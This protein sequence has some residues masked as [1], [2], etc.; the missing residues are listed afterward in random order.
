MNNTFENGLCIIIPA[1]Y[2]ASEYR[3]AMKLSDFVKKQ[4]NLY[5]EVKS[6]DFVTTDDE[7]KK[8][9]FIGLYYY[10]KKMIPKDKLSLP[11][12][13]YYVSANESTAYAYADSIEGYEG[14]YSYVA[15][16]IAQ[17]KLF[18][19]LIYIGTYDGTVQPEKTEKN[20]YRL[21][22]SN[23]LGWC[24]KLPLYYNSRRVRMLAELYNSYSPDVIGLQECWDAPTRDGNCSIVD[25]LAVCGYTEVPVKVKNLRNTNFTPLF[26]KNGKFDLLDYGYMLYDGELNDV[27]SKSVTWALL[28]DKEN[29]NSFIAAATHLF[30]QHGDEGDAGRVRNADQVYGLAKKLCEK[31]N[32]PFILGGDYNCKFGSAAITRFD[33]NGFIN[34]HDN[35]SLADNINTCHSYPKFS[36]ELGIYESTVQDFGDYHKRAIDHVYAYNIKETTKFNRFKIIDELFA[37]EASDHCPVMVDFNL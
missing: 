13:G 18:T 12:Y 5:A 24:D 10:L 26:I 4:L 16:A 29:G 7:N 35:A 3:M 19:E 25:L 37:L 6:A 33:E 27:D 21:L 32:V 11:T 20:G 8:R 1:Q 36:E 17:D 28:R 34:V 2:K 23:V 30:W 14:A 31:Y 22:F 9:I 15:S